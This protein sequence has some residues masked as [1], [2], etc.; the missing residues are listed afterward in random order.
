MDSCILV[1][2]AEKPMAY[3]LAMFRH[4]AGVIETL[5]CDKDENPSNLETVIE[6]FDDFFEAKPTKPTS[7]ILIFAQQRPKRIRQ[8]VH[9]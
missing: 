5:Q 2:L 1:C 7:T 4:A 9:H 3:R 8:R 6:K